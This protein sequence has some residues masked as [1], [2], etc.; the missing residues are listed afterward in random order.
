MARC[1]LKQNSKSN[2]LW[3]ITVAYVLNK[4][5]I[6]RLK[7]NIPEEVWSGNK[8]Q[9]NYLKFFGLVCYKHVPDARRKKLDNKSETMIVVGYHKSEAYRLFNPIREKIII[10]R[11]IIIDE[12]EAWKWTTISQVENLC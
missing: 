2:S 3:D 9:M 11:D 4:C 10:S 1:M 12:N 7:N 6:R 5:P 8:P